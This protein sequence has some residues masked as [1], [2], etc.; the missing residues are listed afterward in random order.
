MKTAVILY[1]G[2]SLLEFS[3]IYEP[4]ARSAQEKPSSGLEVDVCARA[5]EVYDAQGLHFYPT[6]QTDS[7]DEY[8]LVAVPGGPGA[9]RWSQDATMLA[10][11]ATIP[12]T[13]QVVPV[14]SG[15]LLL[16]AA[17]LL[18]GHTAA[19]SA[20][21]QAPLSSFDI[22]TS[23]LPVMLDGPV[24]SA[25]D[26]RA[27]LDLG[28]ALAGSLTGGP[29]LRAISGAAEPVQATSPLPRR[30]HVERKTAETEVTISLNLDGSGKH[31]ID[32]GLPFLDHM[33]TQVTVHGLFDLEIKA[34]GDL[35]IDAHHTLEDVGLALGSAFQQALGDRAG[36]LRMASAEVPMDESLAAVALDFSGRPYAVFQGAWSLPEVGGLANTLF[37]HFLES[38]AQ[39]A[40]C[41]LHAR[42]LYGRDDHHKAEALFKALG[43]AACA[44]TRIDPRRGRQIPSSKGMLV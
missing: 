5:S 22:Q 39:T 19:V 11:L 4:L 24:L 15:A 2:F 3:A 35:H 16:A 13:A 38:F 26:A 28:Q 27:A 40:R 41:N 23:Q 29:P 32:T 7:L 14:G 43:R 30:A 34:S 33:L 10:W 42:I 18:S 21:M 20:G 37:E 31:Q 12:K 36:I 44:A 8:A 9:A 25:A 6:R 1:D 17:G